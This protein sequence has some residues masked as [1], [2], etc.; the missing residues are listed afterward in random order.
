MYTCPT[1]HRIHGKCRRHIQ[2]MPNMPKV[3][4]IML[5]RLPIV[6]IQTNPTFR[7]MLG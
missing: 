7:N 2:W 1:S 6:T 5:L 4:V 3:D